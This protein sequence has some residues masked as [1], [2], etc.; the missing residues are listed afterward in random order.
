MKKTIETTFKNKY[1]KNKNT[2]I[3]KQNNIL[4]YSRE[5]RQLKDDMIS[6]TS[7]SGCQKVVNG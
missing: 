5:R 7:E 6:P 3:K 1:I 4:N 2:E